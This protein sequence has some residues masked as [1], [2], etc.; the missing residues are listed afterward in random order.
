MRD[1]ATLPLLLKQLCLAT[2]YRN[3]ESVAKEAEKQHWT[4]PRYLASLS[5]LE[6]AARYNKRVQRYIK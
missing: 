4:Y 5:E 2:I 3:W 6:V 1:A